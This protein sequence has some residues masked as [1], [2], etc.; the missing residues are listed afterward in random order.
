MEILAIDYFRVLFSEYYFRVLPN[1]DM[2][3]RNQLV[4][5]DQLVASVY[6]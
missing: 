6:A 2:P 4:R 5:H 1:L 3:D